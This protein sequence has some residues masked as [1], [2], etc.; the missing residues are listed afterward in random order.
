MLLA[1]ACY[2]QATPSGVKDDPDH[3]FIDWSR[4]IWGTSPD[5]SKNRETKKEGGLQ[6]PSQASRDTFSDAEV[7]AMTRR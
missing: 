4:A 1:L 7:E 3:Y 5:P 6:A 2:K